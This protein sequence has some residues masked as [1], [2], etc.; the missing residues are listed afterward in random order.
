M[1]VAL[2]EQCELPTGE[3]TGGVHRDPFVV[4]ATGFPGL[5]FMDGSVLRVSHSE[6]VGRLDPGVPEVQIAAS[7]EREIVGCEAGDGCARRVSVACAARV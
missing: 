6:G 1:A 5:A 7:G 2:V 3:L 4:V